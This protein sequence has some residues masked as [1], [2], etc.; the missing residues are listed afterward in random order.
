M[1]NPSIVILN[2]NTCSED[3]TDVYVQSYSR[4]FC[5]VIKICIAHPIDLK[6][7][8]IELCVIITREISNDTGLRVA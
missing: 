7:T 4:K 1:L 6:P 2:E 3:I 8:N 5:G